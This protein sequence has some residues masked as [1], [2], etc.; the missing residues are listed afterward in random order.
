MRDL[1]IEEN[2]QVGIVIFMMKEENLSRILAHPLVG[3]G[4]D[5]EARAPYGLLGRGKPHPR[6][7]GT[8]PRAIGK[9][10]RDEKLLKLEEMLKK[11]T[12]FP[13]KKFGLQ[14][15][16]VVRAENIADLVI[17]DPDKIIDKA[18]WKEPHQYPAGVEYVLVNGEIVIDKGSH[19]GKLP[20][21]ILRKESAL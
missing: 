11:M 4:T 7:Y 20:G 10:V 21:K 5:G 9:Y 8:F 15:R 1:L 12:S 14:K 13:A 17:F 2:D 18:T 3:I 6:V 16:G 19:T